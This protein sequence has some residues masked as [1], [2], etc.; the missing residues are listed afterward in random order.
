M[1]SLI[2]ILLIVMAYLTVKKTLLKN[3]FNKDNM[4]QEFE[5]IYQ[6]SYSNN[7]RGI[8]TQKVLVRVRVFIQYFIP[9]ICLLFLKEPINAI[10]AVITYGILMSI[11]TKYISEYKRTY[12]SEIVS[13]FIKL[14]NNKLVYKTDSEEKLIIEE[15]YREARFDN[16]VFNWFHVEEYI[17]GLLEEDMLVKMSDLR[18][19]YL[20]DNNTFEKFQGIFVQTECDKNIGTYLKISKNKLKIFEKQER[21]EMDSQEFE[22]YFDIYSENR[23]LATEI[24]TSEVMTRLVDFYNKYNIEYEV[25]VRDNKIYI[26]FFTDAILELKIFESDRELLLK[27]F[28]ILK[29]IVDLTKEVN[30]ALKEVEI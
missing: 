10:S 29:F 20:T 13:N 22:K 23:I 2:I 6:E 14:I 21:A 5:N 9:L 4:L 30:K 12:K 19:K 8:K 17:D 27:Y 11:N 25:V 18:I 16:K 1:K 26:R 7:I 3:N 24:L 15:A 28:C